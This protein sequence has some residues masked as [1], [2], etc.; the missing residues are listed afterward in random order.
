MIQNFIFVLFYF[1]VIFLKQTEEWELEQ[2]KT[3]TKKFWKVSLQRNQITTNSILE[4]GIFF[5]KKSM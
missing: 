1:F 2:V 5:G 3:T 4:I